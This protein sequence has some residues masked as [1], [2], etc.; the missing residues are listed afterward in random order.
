MTMLTVQDR[1]TITATI[2]LLERDANVLATHFYNLLLARH[3]QLLPWF[4]PVGLANGEIPRAL[5]RGMLLYARH[6]HELER[7]SD[8][9]S[10]L[11]NRHV[12]LRVRPEHYLLARESVL[13]AMVQVFGAQ[14][15]DAAVIQAWGAA[16]DQ[17][18]ETLITAQSQAVERLAAK[19]SVA[20]AR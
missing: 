2:P 4:D 14:Q 20:A 10:T 12:A 5:A 7:L 15:A 3:P 1:I 19:R 13:D 18:A 9:L 17:L 16:C 8:H 6:I 11:V